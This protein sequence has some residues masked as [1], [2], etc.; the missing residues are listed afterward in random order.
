MIHHISPYAS[1]KY[2]GRALNA[3][4]EPLPNDAWICV[5]DNDTCF[6]TPNS[7]R[8][9]EQAIIDRPDVDLFTCATNRVYGQGLS[10]ESD[11]IVHHDTAS[12]LEM[13]AKKYL[14]IKGCVP[15]FFWLFRKSLWLDNP[16]DDLPIISGNNSFDARWTKDKDWVKVRICH[17]FVFHFYRLNKDKSDY[18]HLK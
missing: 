17:L 12:R 16:F 13:G 15:A 11:I 7:G 18:S 2:L 10:R 6:L 3:H 9:I 14:R 8:L 4:I 1:D 5:R